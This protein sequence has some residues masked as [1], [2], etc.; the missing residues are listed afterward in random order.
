MIYLKFAE[1]FASGSSHHR[2]KM[3]FFFFFV[4]VWDDGFSLKSLWQSL[5]NMYKPSYS[6]IHLQL[7]TV[8]YFKDISIKL[9]KKTRDIGKGKYSFGLH[10][11]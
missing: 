2:K 8:L 7:T 4:S 1:S 5:H 11:I 6:I 9:K 10:N 3:L